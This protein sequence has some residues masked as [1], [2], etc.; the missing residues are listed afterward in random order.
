MGVF[1]NADLTQINLLGNYL[2]SE[3]NEFGR[4]ISKIRTISDQLEN[5]WQGID[6]TKFIENLNSYI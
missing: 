5:S 3:A 1:V 2:V 4:I 6:A